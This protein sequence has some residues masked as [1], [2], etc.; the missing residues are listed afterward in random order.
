MPPLYLFRGTT[1][2][3][4]GNKAAINMPYTCTSIHPAKALWFG[5]ECVPRYSTTPVVYLASMQNLTHL[6]IMQNCL[7]MVEEEIA[8]KI[9]PI[10]FYPLC[11][12]YVFVSE[13]QAILNQFGINAYQ[14][15]NKGNIT[16]LCEQ[17]PP[18][19]D[20]EIEAIVE[21]MRKILKK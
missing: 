18:L 14:I 2:G 20:T 4:Q 7:A 13:M 15:V 16:P 8:F 6:E 21:Q 12:G 5:L 17:T 3:Y 10:E 1:I 9:A 19:G 11:E